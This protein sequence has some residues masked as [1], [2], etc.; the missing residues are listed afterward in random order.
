MNYRNALILPL[1]LL[2]VCS[3]AQIEFG[4]K[5]GLATE[6]LQNEEFSFSREGRQDLKF[7]LEDADYG[8][9]FG[10]LLRLPLTA[11]LTLQP[12]VTLNSARTTF[13]ADDPDSGV[14]EVFK[15]RYNDVNV[16]VL[17]SYKL[18]FLR[19]NAGPVGHFFVSSTSDLK[20]DGGVDR[21]FETFNLGYALGGSIDIGPLTVDVRYD[22]NFANYGETFTFRGEEIDIDQS[23][24]RWIGSIAYRF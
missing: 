11:S 9:Q 6:S 13:R 17:L 23:P 14:S 1:L 10:A 3:F 16:P 8:F 12:E 5:A 24:K 15:E 22:G 4:L 19:L 20:A 18:A 2:S 21:A 7:A